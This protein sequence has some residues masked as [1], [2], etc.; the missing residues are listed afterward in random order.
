ML[1]GDFRRAARPPWT[2]KK[3]AIIMK[4]FGISGRQ[5][6]GLPR[7]IVASAAA[8]IVA[9]GSLIAISGGL[10]FYHL[11]KDYQ[12]DHFL[13]EIESVSNN[14]EQYFTRITDIAVQVTSRTK[15]REKLEA[16]NDGRVDLEELQAFSSPILNDALN[17][18]ASIV[19]I[20]RFD[21]RGRPVIQTGATLPLDLMPPDL[22]QITAPRLRGPYSL[23]NGQATVV[24]APIR[25]RQNIIVG[26]DAVAFDFDELQTQ[27]RALSE[28]KSIQHVYLSHRTEGRFD[29]LFEYRKSDEPNVHNLDHAGIYDSVILRGQSNRAHLLPLESSFGQNGAI[30]YFLFDQTGWLLAIHG[31]SAALYTP[32]Y[33]V[34]AKYSLMLLVI[35]VLGSVAT[36]RLL[37]PLAERIISL[38]RDLR[39][40][41]RERQ[42][43]ERALATRVVQQKAVAD[44]GQYCLSSAEIQDILDRAVTMAADTLQVELCKVLE[45]G[46][47]RDTLLLRAGVG[48]HDGLVGIAEVPL[49]KDSQAGYTLNS[50]EAVAVADLSTEKRFSGPQLLIDHQVRSGVSV[51]IDPLNTW[52]VFGIHSTRRRVFTEDDINFVQAITNCIAEAIERRRAEDASKASEARFRALYDDNPAMFITVGADF[53]IDSINQFGARQLG[54]AAD[55][56][57]GLPIERISHHEDRAL[58]L[59]KLEC[60]VTKDWS[61]HRWELRKKR[62]DGSTMWVRETARVVAGPD[63]DKKIL[64]VC[65]DVSEARTLSEQLSFEASH[66]P[67][68]RLVNRREFENR[69]RVLIDSARKGQSEHILC[70]L[71]LDQFKI[72]NDTCGHFAGD[73]LLCQV[74]KLL[75]GS[76]RKGDTVARLGGDEFGL[77]LQHCDVE[78]ALEIAN[79]L[80]EKVKEF[81]FAWEQSTFC[82]GVS[83]GL[84]AITDSSGT[85]SDLLRNADTACYA[86]KDAGGNRVHVY[87][88]DDTQLLKRHGE[89]RWVARINDALD[90][91]R[92]RLF[93]Q[94]ILPLQKERSDEIHHELLIRLP[95]ADGSMILPG[96]FLP[97]AE[98]YNLAT[99]ID[100]WVIKSLFEYFAVHPDL[101]P[102]LG[103][104]SIN[105]SGQS[106]ADPDFFAYVVNVLIDNPVAAKRLCFEITETAAI[107]DVANALLFIE[108]I[109]GH[110]CRF[111]LDDFGSGLSSFGYL[112]TLPV[113]YLKIDG[114]FVKNIVDDPA[115][116]AMV[117]SIHEIGKSLG[118]TTIAEYVENEE[119]KRELVK[120]GVD[121]VQGYGIGMPVPLE[122][123]CSDQENYARATNR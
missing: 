71:D 6:I 82:V 112:K 35:T 90:E 13:F 61:I 66:D 7:L 104:C 99:R 60:C 21:R 111:A 121:F 3:P 42:S 85:L 70:Y 114:I 57:V 22:A 26:I 53:R 20:T 27:L 74:A 64:I 106:M 122:D 31:S 11:L 105:L 49:D 23:T 65:E 37:R 79:G 24:L 117:K 77:F 69:L 83:M 1:T 119:I 45:L 116:R 17:L 47:D 44:L 118:K 58:L 101:L 36:Y 84:V 97:A 95:D 8:G 25:N 55:D 40:E 98:R 48:W 33:S 93:A 68:T 5:P 51:I 4:L 80:L 102:K 28:R 50:M 19:A 32:V 54:Y 78:Q 92:F 115:D 123:L 29:V 110:G 100:E 103:I 9:I 18:N 59:H 109:K 12:E 41:I 56:V 30:A 62:R 63:N 113:D 14:V 73:Q 88:N 67:L 39:G 94:P 107:S 2:M 43:V 120:I 87:Q 89:M 10:P 72:I 38:T 81:R 52:G 76:L 34:L 91:N 108:E 86:A 16:F 75:Q 15:A 46:P 96:A